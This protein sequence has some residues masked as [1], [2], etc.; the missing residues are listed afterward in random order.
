MIT[1]R[2]LRADEI[3]VRVAQEGDGW[4]QLLLYKNARVDMDILDETFTPLG[5]QRH[6]SRDNANCIVSIWD[7]EKKQWI[8]KEDTGI[9]SNTQK[10]KGL[11]SD[12]FKR[13]CVNVGIGREL[14]TS[15]VICVWETDKNEEPNYCYK[16]SKDKSKKKLKTRFYVSSIDIID[17]VITGLTITNN[18]NKVVFVY[19]KNKGGKE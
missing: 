19:K 3:D 15:P 17:K 9:E 4:L 13:A 6:H 8:D 12:S 7:E 5:W 14:Y 2:D 16:E 18:D 1:I 11:A 10:E